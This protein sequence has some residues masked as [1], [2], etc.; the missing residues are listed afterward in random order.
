MKLKGWPETQLPHPLLQKNCE[1]GGGRGSRKKSLKSVLDFFPK[2]GVLAGQH[3]H[4]SNLSF[5]YEG[6]MA[7]SF[8]TERECINAICSH[9]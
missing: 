1:L 9:D 7:S 2:T 8:G 6:I 3:G 4:N 5:V